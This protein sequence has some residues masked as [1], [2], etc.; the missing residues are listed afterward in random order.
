MYALF[1]RAVSLVR[2]W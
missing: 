2:T 1:L